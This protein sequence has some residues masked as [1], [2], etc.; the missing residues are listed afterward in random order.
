MTEKDSTTERKI[1]PIPINPLTLFLFKAGVFYFFWELMNSHMIRY[2]WWRNI[3]NAIHDYVLM[4]ILDISGVLITV[5]SSEGSREGIIIKVAD[6]P[7]VAVGP[8]CVAMGIM[9]A[10]IALIVSY[11]GSWK[12]KLWFVPFGLFCIHMFNVA[13]VL[14]LAYISYFNNF[15]VDFNHKYVFNTLLYVLVFLLWVFWANYVERSEKLKM[16]TTP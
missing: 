15:I 10:F 16:Q 6:S 14:A 7:G 8:G 13:R 3:W 12:S 5:I 4:S 9:Y 1:G 2:A 11:H